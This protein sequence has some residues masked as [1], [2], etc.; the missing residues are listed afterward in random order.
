MTSNTARRSDVNIYIT[1]RVTNWKPA[2][3]SSQPPGNMLIFLE[4]AGKAS[5]VR[6]NFIQRKFRNRHS[7]VLCSVCF[8]LCF[9]D[10]PSGYDARHALVWGV[11]NDTI[12][13]GNVRPLQF[14]T[15]SKPSLTDLRLKCY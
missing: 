10:R 8:S 6:K 12:S 3:P 4:L 2:R 5:Q 13:A 9:N 14:M 7:V 15:S 1:Y 11:V